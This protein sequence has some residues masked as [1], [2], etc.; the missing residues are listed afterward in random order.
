MHVNAT[1]IQTIRDFSHYLNIYLNGILPADITPKR[2]EYILQWIIVRE[3][4][5]VYNLF[6]VSNITRR[7]HYPFT[8]YDKLNEVM[9]I[10]LSSVFSNYIKA[11]RIYADANEIIVSIKNED[12]FI[13]YNGFIQ[14]LHTL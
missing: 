14:N 2:R 7:D 6:D 5:Q 3:L 13:Q 12:L 4:E 10:P 1:L 9:P 8:I 11:P